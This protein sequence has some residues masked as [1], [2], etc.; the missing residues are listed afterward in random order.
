MRRRLHY[1]GPQVKVAVWTGIYELGV[2][3]TPGRVLQ[4]GVLGRRPV[5]L[6]QQSVAVVGGCSGKPIRV[7]SVLSAHAQAVLKPWQRSLVD[8][9]CRARGD[10]RGPLAIRVSQKVEDDLGV[11]RMDPRPMDAVLQG[12]GGGHSLPVGHRARDGHCP[13]AGEVGG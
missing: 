8:H 4:D 2:A 3:G 13:S 10:S 5:R 12:E 11:N 7:L 9:L 1:G 6:V